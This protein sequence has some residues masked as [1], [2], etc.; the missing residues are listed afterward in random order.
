[1]KLFA[2][3]KIKGYAHISLNTL[4]GVVRSSELSLCT[5]DEIKT[6][7]QNQGVSNVKS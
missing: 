5:L 6:H 7:L 1:M 4:K 2:G 3:L